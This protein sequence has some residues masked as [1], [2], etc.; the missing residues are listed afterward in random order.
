MSHGTGLAQ[1]TLL[2]CALAAAAEPIIGRIRANGA[3][4]QA[5]WAFLAQVYAN[6][7]GGRPHRAPW[8]MPRCALL[9][10]AGRLGPPSV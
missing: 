5:E 3:Q 9:G 6:G 4:G 10:E 7:V 2:L 8:W 1:P